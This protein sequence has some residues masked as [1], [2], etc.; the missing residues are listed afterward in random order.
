LGVFANQLSFLAS[1]SLVFAAILFFAGKLAMHYGLISSLSLFGGAGGVNSA[2]IIT[3]G[4]AAAAPS[5]NPLADAGLVSPS[6]S[7][8]APIVLAATPNRASDVYL[9]ILMYHYIRY[10]PAG[11]KVG[12]N[13]SVTPPDFQAQMQWLS[14]HGYTT[15]TMRDATLMI[16]KRKPLPPRAIAL[17]FDD[18]YEDFYTAAVP[19]LKQFGFTATD[20]VPTRLVGLPAYMTWDQVQEL[21]QSGFEMAAHTQFHVGLGRSNLDRARTEVFGSESDLETHLGHPVT[22]FCYPYGSFDPAVVALVKS[23]GFLSATSTINGVWHDSAQMYDLTRVRVGGGE[24]IDYWSRTFAPTNLG[25]PT[26]DSF[27]SV[28][29]G[30]SA[31]SPSA[32]AGSPAPSPTA[33]SSPPSAPPHGSP[34]PS[35]SPSASRRP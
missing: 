6:P 20:Y 14:D 27:G 11:D 19:V 9:P 23:A 12:W 13:L 26:T 28:G 2:M 5:V 30:P 32:S 7:G 25:W 8:K 22:D 15:V 10:A 21:D 35:P 3:Q 17:T 4:R 33:S 16:Q 1:L 24:T 18:G 34:S 31:A 29:A